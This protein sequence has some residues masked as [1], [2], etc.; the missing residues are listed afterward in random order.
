M[1]KGY[2]PYLTLPV[3]IPDKVCIS[4]LLFGVSKNVL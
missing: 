1:L 3:S 2:C 4:A